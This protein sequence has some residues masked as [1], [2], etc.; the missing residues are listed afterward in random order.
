MNGQFSASVSTL[1]VYFPHITRSFYLH[2]AVLCLSNVNVNDPQTRFNGFCKVTVAEKAST[3]IARFDISR[4]CTKDTKST[5]ISDV[6][7]LIL[8]L[9]IFAFQ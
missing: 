6:K 8:S 7:C 4:A 3:V 9:C 2:C 1:S 5:A